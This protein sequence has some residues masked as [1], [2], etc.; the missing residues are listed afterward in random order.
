MKKTK[1]NESRTQPI[2]KKSKK[3]NIN[4]ACPS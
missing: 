4:G 2:H 1:T 3:S